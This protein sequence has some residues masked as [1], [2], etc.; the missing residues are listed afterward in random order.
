MV[1]SKRNW[2]ISAACCTRPIA[3][4]EK[5]E[6]RKIV[7]VSHEGRAKH[8]A[9][10][11]KN[12]HDSNKQN[13]FYLFNTLGQLVNQ[14]ETILFIAYKNSAYYTYS[15]IKQPVFDTIYSPEGKQLISEKNILTFQ[16]TNSMQLVQ[17]RLDILLYFQLSFQNII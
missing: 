9:P 8:C 11:S 14:T 15:E 1:V 10:K 4:V 16:N 3:G 6:Y 5:Q 13:S 17:L 7:Y 2:T 12:I